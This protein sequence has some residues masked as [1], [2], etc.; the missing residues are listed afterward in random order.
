M[1]PHQRKMDWKQLYSGYLAT[2][3][4]WEN[5]LDGLEQLQ[6][7]DFPTPSLQ[8]IGNSNIRLGFLAEHFTFDFW[9]QA[10]DIDLLARNIQVNGAN[11]TL[12][13]IDAI[14]KQDNQFIHVEIA[15]KIYLYDP[16]HGSSALDHW[17]GPNRKDSLV[18]K[19]ER[20]K[21]HQLPLVAQPEARDA[22]SP[23]ISVMES[24]TSKVWIK[25][26]LFMPK[27]TDIDISPL[28]KECIVGHY[29]K[30]NAL[31]QYRDCRFFLPSKQEWMIVPHTHVNWCDFDTIGEE[32]DGLLAREYSPMIWTKSATGA[33]SRMF[34][35]WWD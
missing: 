33:L 26:L 21:T 9:Q 34:V 31:E 25:S 10:P 5:S 30:R 4:L 12:G 11:E 1:K 24:I 23:W 18:D 6:V 22:L 35:V 13:E 3:L 28:N 16:K 7:A 14:M 8:E 27:G 15:F 20:F 2:S 17:I 29:I 19:L 32:I